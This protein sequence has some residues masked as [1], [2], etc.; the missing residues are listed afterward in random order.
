M[1]NDARVIS[2]VLVGIAL[3]IADPGA[4]VAQ[5]PGYNPYRPVKGLA[6]GGGAAMPGP[7]LAKL[8][9]ER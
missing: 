7:E 4:G 6:E 8:P 2:M 5:A 3:L 9:G 1:S